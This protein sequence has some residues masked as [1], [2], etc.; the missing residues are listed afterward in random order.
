MHCNLESHPIR[1]EGGPPIW[2]KRSGAESRATY[3]AKAGRKRGHPS[4]RVRKVPPK[5]KE[6]G[7]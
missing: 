1:L 6:V 7:G 5:G 3:A 4:E 2:G